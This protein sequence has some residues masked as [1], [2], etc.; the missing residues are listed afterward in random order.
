VRRTSIGILFT[1]AVLAATMFAAPAQARHLTLKQLKTQLR[2]AKEQRNDVRSQFKAAEA[3]LEGALE[4]QAGVTP[5]EAAPEEPAVADAE[6]ALPEPQAT[7]VAPPAGMDPVLV[8]R[9]LDDGAVT[10]DEVAALQADVVTLRKSLRRWNAKVTRLQKR[11]RRRVQ[12]IEWNRRGKW[13]P[14]IEIAGREYGV[15]PNKLHRMMMLESGGRRY[16][17]STYKGLFQ[18]HPSTWSGGWNP[19]RRQSVY[20]GWA[21]IRATAYALS[22]GMGPSQWPHTYRMAF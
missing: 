9:L 13:R 16:A 5:A 10:T 20:D 6:P 3:N 1:L 11:V 2:H 22:K 15:N 14:L 7:T 4:L 21:Q 17:G 8:A 18:Y 12:I 19:W